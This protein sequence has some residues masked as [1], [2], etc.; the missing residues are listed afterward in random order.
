MS[1]RNSNKP[2]PSRRTFLHRAILAG[3]GLPLLTRG[4]YGGDLP[5]GDYRDPSRPLPAGNPLRRPAV[6]T[7]TDIHAAV[8][9]GEVWPGSPTPLW[10]FGGSYPS[11]TIRVRRGEQFTMKLYNDLPEK[12]SI[13]WHGLVVPSDMDGHPRN[14]VAPG[15]T[16]DYSFKIDQRAG[17]Y[18]YHPHPHEATAK[19]VYMGM[20]GLFIVEDD[21]ELVLKLPSGEFEVPLV[22]QDRRQ[23]GSTTIA[24][25]P[26]AM[27]HQDGYLG[28]TILVNGTPDP[29]LEVAPGL[30][31]F[32]I[33]NGSNARILDLALADGHKLTVIGTDGGLLDKPYDVSY[34]YLAPAE[35]VDLVIDFSGYAPG[36]SVVLKSLPYSGGAGTGQ[37]VEFDIL[38]FDIVDR[39][40][41]P[42]PLP[43][44]LTTLNFHNAAE[45][46]RTRSF[47]LDID[48]SVT[49][50]MHQINGKT[51]E[52]DRV[53][54]Q[55]NAG[56]LEIWEFQNVT[57][58]P[59]PIHIHGLQFQ[60]LDRN[61][62]GPLDPVDAGWKDTVF[63][64]PFQTIH[65]LIR[66][67]EHLG[68]FLFHCHN[69]EHEDEGMMLNYEVIAGNTGV[70][71][72]GDGMRDGGMD[73]R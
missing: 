4:L 13:H 6:H 59:H 43:A 64:R 45:A 51:F 2:D 19:Q 53:D 66:F 55:V 69:L 24:Y 10:T 32:R 58:L 50:N 3:V 35:R 71:V 5:G 30:Y 57:L 52:M 26:V 22:I 34:T 48:H 8:I 72:R 37:G 73:L 70:D 36:T 44:A 65:L 39:P 18:W 28:D 25:A 49:M 62:T 21:E 47:R 12:T 61:G 7:G 1:N 11:P 40:A 46:L 20:A 63:M 17:T 68:L 29:Y 38:R 23:A 67:Q 41:W 56:D 9:E 54:E 42:N 27:D 31:R 33:L 15:G 60:L 16:F 14:A